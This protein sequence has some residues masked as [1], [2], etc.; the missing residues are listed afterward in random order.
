[1]GPGGQQEDTPRI[2]VYFRGE[3]TVSLMGQVWLRGYWGEAGREAH[4]LRQPGIL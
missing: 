3:L 2:W 4:N 1:M